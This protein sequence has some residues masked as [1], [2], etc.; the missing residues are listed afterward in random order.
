M[1]SESFWNVLQGPDS[2]FVRVLLL[3]GRMQV[4][5]LSTLLRANMQKIRVPSADI[6]PQG[7][8]VAACHSV[9]AACYQMP[10]P[11]GLRIVVL[12][13]L[14][15]A[16]LIG[17]TDLEETFENLILAQLDLSTYGPDLLDP[18]AELDH[19]FD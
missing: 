7:K 9:P 11:A 15:G 17:D 18:D 8:S 2:T 12:T 10:N 13:K 5:P 14:Q 1:I 4:C 3:R 6:K 16:V 19:I